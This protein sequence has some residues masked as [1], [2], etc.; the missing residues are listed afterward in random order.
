MA[1]TEQ[2]FAAANARGRARLSTMPRATAASYDAERRR[3]VLQLSTGLEVAFAPQ[4]V[5]GLEG[6]SPEDLVEVEI[7]PPGFGIRFPRLDADL[8]LP[9]LLEGFFGSKSWAAA[10]LGQAGGRASTP[11][12]RAAS[13]ANGRHGGRPRTAA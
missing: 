12:K 2:E 6:A 10:R 13:R 4:D 11:A 5:Q 8:Y 3:I 1:I 9:A 7:D